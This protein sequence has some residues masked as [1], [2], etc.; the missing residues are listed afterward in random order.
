MLVLCQAGN[1][2]QCRLKGYPGE[3]LFQS[4]RSVLLPK[5]LQTQVQKC[6]LNLSMLRKTEIWSGITEGV[7]FDGLLY[8]SFLGKVGLHVVLMTLHGLTQGH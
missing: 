5:H 4:P 6:G 1:L 8:I 3:I 2:H 7:Q